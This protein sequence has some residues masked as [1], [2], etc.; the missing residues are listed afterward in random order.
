METVRTDMVKRGPNRPK[1]QISCTEIANTCRSPQHDDGRDFPHSKDPN[2]D[3]KEH[4]DFSSMTGYGAQRCMG[5]GGAAASGAMRRVR[6]LGG[7]G[8]AAIC[9]RSA[10]ML[11][12]TPPHP[13]SHF[14]AG[15]H[16]ASLDGPYPDPR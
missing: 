12:G 1:L 10:E 8:Q 5:S 9:D 6:S 14:G 2:Y 11:F 15:M 4:V 13:S 7:F 3:Y 16:R